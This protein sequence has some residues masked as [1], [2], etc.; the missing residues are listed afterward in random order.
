MGFRNYTLFIARRYLAPTRRN[1]FVSFITAI[2]ILGVMFGTAALLISLSIL[3]GFDETLRANMISFVGHIEVTSFK[4]RPL[5]G[6]REVVQT[7]PEQVP[8]VEKVSPFVRR[9]AILR[10]RAGLEGVLLKGI[11]PEIDVSTIRDKIVRGRFDL[12]DAGPDAPSPIVLGE[13]LA[14]K[15]ALDIGDTAVLFAPEGMPSPDN[16]PAIEQFVVAGIYKTGMA[17]YDDIYTYTSLGGAQ[18]LYEIAPDVVSGYDILVRNIDSVEQTARKLDVVLGW[19]HYP[20]TVFDI[21]QAFFAWLDLQ[22]VPIPIV[23]ALISIVAIF[24]IISTLLIVILEKTESIGVLSTLGARRV[25]IMAIFVGQGLLIGSVGTGLGSLLSLGFALVQTR[26]K[27][28]SLD[29][30]IYFIDAVPVSLTPWHYLLVISASI[31]LCTLS[32]LIPA[33]VASR[34]RPVA[35]LRFQ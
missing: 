16:P 20:Q 5:T 4:G 2:S 8:E 12:T 7:L 19:P 27:L 30:D 3:Q 17:E 26:F 11:I 21:F 6:Y 23:L 10:S 32:T 34:L 24:N 29:A 22:R 28:I 9:E 33:Y 18:R 1:R 31:A 13:R 25:D 14:A 35:A 15:L